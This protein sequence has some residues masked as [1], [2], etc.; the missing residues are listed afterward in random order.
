MRLARAYQWPRQ[1]HCRG[2]AALRQLLDRRPA[3]IGQA[4]Q[5]RGLVEGFSGGI[6]DGRREAA[7]IAEPPHF[8]QLAMPARDEQQ[9][10]WKL[11]VG[12]G[13]ARRQ[14]MAFE[15]IDGDQRL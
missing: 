5:L 8:E 3:G 10:I 1:W 15:M 2:I 13:K 12:V 4:E 6:V 11:E 9:H 14:R 7:I